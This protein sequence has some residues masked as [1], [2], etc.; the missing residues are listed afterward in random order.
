MRAGGGGQTQRLARRRPAQPE[1]GERGAE[2]VSGA[3]RV[4]LLHREGGLE[5]RARR[6]VMADARSAQLV[7]HRADPKRQ[8][9]GHRGLVILGARQQRQFLAA[10]QEQVGQPEDF[11][12]RRAQAG[13]VEDFLAQVR[14]EGERAAARL[15]RPRRAQVQR[16]EIR[17]RQRRAHDVQVIGPGQRGVDTV[18]GR[19]APAG[20][21]TD[22]EDEIA[23]AVGAIADEGAAGRA[24]GIDR[25]G[26]DVDAVAFQPVEI[27]PP[28]IVVADAGDDGAGL[29]Q[30]RGLVDEDRRRAGR[31]RPGQR[32]RLAKALA[33][34]VGHDLDQNLADDEHLLHRSL[35]LARRA[36]PQP[37][38]DP[39]HWAPVV[40]TER[41][42][43]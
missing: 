33:R 31:E 12:H 2:A 19:Q 28:E 38:L 6:V 36:G 39:C 18:L 35:P 23:R 40:S 21:V 3:G 30:P 26:R 4:D 42:R 8:Q 9:F 20:A 29:A 1:G 37:R 24:F 43:A 7:D 32:Q 13:R 10:R 27:D 34:R 25:N 14:V 15:E 16:R 11:R 5:Q 41:C 17:A 22:V